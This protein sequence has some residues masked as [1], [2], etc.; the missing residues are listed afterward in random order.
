MI[1]QMNPFKSLQKAKQNKLEA[2]NNRKIEKEHKMIQRK[3]TEV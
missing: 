1:I 3:K 2:K